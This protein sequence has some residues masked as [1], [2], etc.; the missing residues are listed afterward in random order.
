[1]RLIL[2]SM[3][4]VCLSI[5]GNAQ[6]VKTYLYVEMYKE[7]VPTEKLH[8]QTEIT[9]DDDAYWNIVVRLKDENGITRINFHT[10]SLLKSSYD[11]NNNYCNYYDAESPKI[12]SVLI[13][14][15]TNKLYFSFTYGDGRDKVLWFISNK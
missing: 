9:W 1:M 6:T 15:P 8:N 12:P 7:G 13:C 14:S 3:I 5:P 11:Q 10:K 2:L 4:L